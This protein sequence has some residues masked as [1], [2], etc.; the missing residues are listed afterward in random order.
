MLGLLCLLLSAHG[1]SACPP[2]V[3]SVLEL[4]PWQSLRKEGGE[5]CKAWTR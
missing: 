5:V 2:V 4:K 3:V 1:C